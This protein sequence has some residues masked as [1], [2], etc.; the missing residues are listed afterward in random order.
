MQ[1]QH[2]SIHINAPR[3]KVWEKTI[4]EESFK[5]WTTPFEPS[6]FF[7]GEWEKGSRIDFL[8]KHEDGTES[9][10]ISEIAD[11]RFPEFISIRHLGEINK[12]VE[13]VES[14]RVKAWAPAYENY[15]L[16]ETKDGTEFIVDSDTA[17]EYADMLEMMWPKALQKLK[18]VCEN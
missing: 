4:G 6:S 15:T 11:I 3:E 14:D 9:G 18:E 16:E 10:M 13:D 8:M 5:Q 2:F 12:G 1:K 7:R 17:D